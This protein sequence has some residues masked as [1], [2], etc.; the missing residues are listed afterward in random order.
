MNRTCPYTARPAIGVF[1]D[2]DALFGT[3]KKAVLLTI[4]RTSV[5]RV[6]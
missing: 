6:A 1:G 4:Y 5:S 2:Y 3:M